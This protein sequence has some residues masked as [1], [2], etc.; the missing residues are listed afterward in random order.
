MYQ[1]P[2]TFLLAHLFRHAPEEVFRHLSEKDIRVLRHAVRTATMEMPNYR[3]SLAKFDMEPFYMNS[4]Q[5][6]KF[7]AD[8]VKKEKAIIE[9]GKN[10]MFM[11]LACACDRLPPCLSRKRQ[12]WS[13]TNMRC[14]DRAG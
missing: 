10:E 14:S 4:E 5:Y 11:N 1:I 6:A 8:T 12:S 13:R 9:S 2:D 3:E 7:A